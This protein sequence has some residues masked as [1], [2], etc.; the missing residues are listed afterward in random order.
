MYDSYVIFNAV[1]RRDYGGRDLTAYLGKLLTSEPVG[2][3]PVGYPDIKSL[4]PRPTPS[5]A[6]NYDKEKKPPESPK[7]TMSINAWSTHWPVL[8]KRPAAWRPITE[9]DVHK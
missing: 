9:I 3:R 6:V 8:R 7:Y 5:R 1:N 4:S 2:Y